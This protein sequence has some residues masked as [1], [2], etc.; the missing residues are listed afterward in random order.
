MQLELRRELRPLKVMSIKA[1]NGN[2][3]T[4]KHQ[5]F[6]VV[7][8]FNHDNGAETLP[9]TLQLPALKT[10]DNI[11]QLSDAQ[12]NTYLDR[13]HIQRQGNLS[14]ETKLRRLKEF[15]GCTVDE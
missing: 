6:E 4:G 15:L 10:I 5:S 8:F 1:Y 11:Y 13:Y 9:E 3:G 12:L 2:C 14:R 7:S